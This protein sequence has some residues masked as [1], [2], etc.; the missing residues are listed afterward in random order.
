VCEPICWNQKAGLCENC[1]PDL[2]EEIAAAQAAAARDQV[3]EK[4]RTVDWLKER[5]V[6]QVSGAVCGSCGAKTKG[7]KFCHDCGAPLQA[8]KKCNDCGHEVEGAPK[9]CPECGGRY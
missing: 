5:K 3:Q 7:G 1:A 6:D 4:A 2:D 9:F 8:K